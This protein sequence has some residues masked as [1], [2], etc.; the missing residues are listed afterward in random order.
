MVVLPGTWS[1]VE[2]RRNE[3][4]VLDELLLAL[5]EMR[6]AGAPCAHGTRAT[7]ASGSG[8]SPSTSPM[9]STQWLRRVARRC[10]QGAAR[11][12][13]LRRLRQ[14]YQPRRCLRLLGVSARAP[15]TS[16]QHRASPRRRLT[17]RAR[18]G[19]IA[20]DSGGRPSTR[21]VEMLA[22]A[23]G[24]TKVCTGRGIRLTRPR[25]IEQTGSDVRTAGA[26]YWCRELRER[27]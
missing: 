21:V 26:G 3:P 2:S 16:S 14:Q 1:F 8:S 4:P 13:R 18:L 24:A 10:P 23:T 25:R 19:T 17:A 9:A 27:R 7:S 12:R 22:S 5:S 6:T 11:Y 20:T 15:T